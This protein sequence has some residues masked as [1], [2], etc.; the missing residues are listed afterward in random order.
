MTC[1]LSQLRFLLSSLVGA[2][3]TP[4]LITLDRK[5]R[6]G[7]TT[8]Q[9]P[10]EAEP[11]LPAIVITY[12]TEAGLD[13][14]KM[15]EPAAFTKKYTEEIKEHAHHNDTGSGEDL[16]CAV[17]THLT[18][19]KV[20]P[21]ALSGSVEKKRALLAAL[22]PFALPREAGAKVHRLVEACGLEDA[23]LLPEAKEEMLPLPVEDDPEWSVEE[24]SLEEFCNTAGIDWQKVP[25]FKAF[26]DA[27]K[28]LLRII[29]GEGWDYHEKERQVV[30]DRLVIHLTDEKLTTQA[31]C[32][33]LETH[34]LLMTK[35]QPF[36]ITDQPSTPF[37]AY[38]KVLEVY[39]L[40]PYKFTEADRFVK[41]HQAELKHYNE[42]AS[43]VFGSC[44]LKERAG[45]K[46]YE[47]MVA[48]L[49]KEKNIDWNAPAAV[50]R[51]EDIMKQFKHIDLL[52]F[53]TK[54]VVDKGYANIPT[55]LIKRF[56]KIHHRDVYMYRFH[57]GALAEKKLYQ[58]FDAFL[59]ATS[60]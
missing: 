16:W 2:D 55:E 8:L 29:S 47:E 23:W 22:Q 52:E 19:G 15:P 14:S 41:E 31:H 36:F 3:D 51:A 34:N 21:V 60:P 27:N 18:Q 32:D 33:S 6:V 7:V 38:I 10:L 59:D 12:L 11:S 48:H 57:L 25:N 45:R 56:V 17:V 24:E 43:M 20:K 40:N 28:E 44:P 53:F 5:L 49:L 50:A 35:L 46:I 26:V 42:F 37:A 4:V 39:N 13:P 58:H 30:Y 9:L 1:T 54:D